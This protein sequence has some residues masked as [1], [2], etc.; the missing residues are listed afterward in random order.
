M[1][2]YVPFVEG[3]DISATTPLDT[4]WIQAIPVAVGMWTTDKPVVNLQMTKVSN[5]LT[6][7]DTTHIVRVCTLASA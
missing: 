6:Y 7:Y 1:Y 5:N 2:M 4:A 3:D